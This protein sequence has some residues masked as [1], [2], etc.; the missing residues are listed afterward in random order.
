MVSSPPRWIGRTAW[1]R[2]LQTPLRAFLRTETGGAAVLVGAT[3]LA[4]V[5]VDVSTSS[6]DAVWHT[7]LSFRLGAW[8]LG[9][10]LRGWVNDGLMTLFFF[11]VGLEARREFDLGELRDRR[12]VMQ[13]VLAAVGG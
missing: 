10:D 13:P 3:V 8:S 7:E 5:W 11:T 1:A 9:Q 4:L 6:Y 2:N 12:R